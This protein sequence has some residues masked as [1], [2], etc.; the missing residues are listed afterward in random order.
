M[1]DHRPELLPH[2]AVLRI[3]QRIGIVHAEGVL[4]E[5]VN[6]E[7]ECPRITGNPVL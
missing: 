5:A 6:A 2:I 3:A 4:A 7:M 1:E